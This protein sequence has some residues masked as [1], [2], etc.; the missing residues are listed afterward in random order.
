[1]QELTQAEGG[2]LGFTNGLITFS[3]PYAAITS[4]LSLSAHYGTTCSVHRLTAILISRFIM[5]LQEAHLRSVMI[6]SEDAPRISTFW[7]YSFRSFISARD[8]ADASDDMLI[9]DEAPPLRDDLDDR[10]AVAVRGAEE[11][12]RGVADSWPDA[13]MAV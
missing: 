9:R 11:R 12:S 10:E 6:R 1:M 5:D 3:T 8:T 13:Q 4:F 7:S 2:A